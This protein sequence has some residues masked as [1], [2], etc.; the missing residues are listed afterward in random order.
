MEN[1]VENITISLIDIPGKIATIVSLYK[2]SIKYDN[3]SIVYK[4]ADILNK[5]KLST[6][7]CFKGK[8]LLEQ[9]DFIINVIKLLEKRYKIAIYSGYVSEYID[10]HYK[11]LLSI[12][13]VQMLKLGPLIRSKQVYNKYLGSS[14]QELYLKKYNK[15]YKINWLEMDI[16]KIILKIDYI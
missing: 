2:C 9:T 13:E 8:D 7:I 14:N 5:K 11:L 12:P 16:E 4:L 10:N 6:W 15:W 3:E 1:I